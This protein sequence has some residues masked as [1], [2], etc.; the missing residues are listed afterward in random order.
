MFQQQLQDMQK[1]MD[2][3]ISETHKIVGDGQQNL[4]HTLQAQ[5]AQSSKIITDITEKLTT[6]DKT[7]QQVIGFSSQLSDLEKVLKH[8][9]QRGNLGEVG[10]QLLR[11][12][13]ISK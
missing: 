12:Y 11:K 5:F 13:F 4:H 10:L 1:T 2:S 8:Q 7:N 6:L 9:K 3:K